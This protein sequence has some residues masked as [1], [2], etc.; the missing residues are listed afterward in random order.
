MTVADKDVSNYDGAPI[1]LYDF[2]RRSVPTLTGVLV[3]THWRFT[4][5][6]RDFTLGADVYAATAIADDGIRQSG[7]TSA[8]QLTITMPHTLKIPQMF[9]GSPPSDPIYCL[10]R[11]ANEGETDSF[12]AWA[13]IVGMVS[14]AASQEDGA[15]IV[16]SVVCNTVSATMDRTGL[17]LA[18]SRS[19]PHDLYGFE[20]QADPR[21]FVISG[22][23]TALDGVSITVAET[24]GVGPVT[25]GPITSTR[26]ADGGAGYA[27]LDTGWIVGGNGDA[28]YQILT[29]DVAGRVLTFTT[30]SQGT[31]YVSASGTTTVRAGS[32]PGIGVGLKFDISA[33]LIGGE[34]TFS[35]GFIEWIDEDGHANRLGITGHDSGNG[36]ITVLGT[37]DRLTVGVLVHCFLGC[38]R[39]R[40]TCH[41]VFDN[42]V[43]HGGHAYMPDNSPFS[44]D[45]IF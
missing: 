26:L 41:N 10:I 21:Q 14:R 20:C 38:D 25:S 18:W 32:Q 6:D 23:V 15:S 22:L 44:G 40:T 43:N 16:A 42:I 11:H 35:G 19:C 12:I 28:N 37:A 31:D 45:I 8:D 13:G 30:T 2:Y 33:A 29:V 34:P 7:N 5:A 3:E 27:A 17:R 24:I 4:S 39:L 9:V 36:Q 1:M